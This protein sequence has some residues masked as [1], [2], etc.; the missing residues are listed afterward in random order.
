MPNYVR[1]YDV[2]NRQ[3][4]YVHYPV[5]NALLGDFKNAAIA[6]RY[7]RKRGRG[8][9]LLAFL[10]WLS[11]PNGRLNFVNLDTHADCPLTSRERRRDSP[12]PQTFHAL[13]VSCAPHNKGSLRLSEQFMARCLES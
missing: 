2:C 8:R 6:Y 1:T 12:N 4:S 13:N 11:S 5:R 10:A 7:I 3:V 9:P